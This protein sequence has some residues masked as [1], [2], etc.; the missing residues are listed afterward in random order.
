[1]SHSFEVMLRAQR[2]TDLFDHAVVGSEIVETKPRRTRRQ[3]HIDQ[4]VHYAEM[5][6]IK[7]VFLFPGQHA[8]RVVAF[9]GIEEQ[10]GTAG[11]CARAGQNLAEETGVPVCLVDAGLP[12]L[13]DYLGV[14]NALTMTADIPQPASIQ[15]LAQK[16]D[17]ENLFF[18]SLGQIFEG[19]G[20]AWKSDAWPSRLNELRRAF[21]YVLLAAPPVSSN[22][23]TVLLGKG[24]DGVIL[25]L[26]S[27]LTRRER[28]RA[29]KQSFEEA[30]VQLLGAVLNNHVHAIPDKLY[31]MF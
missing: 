8:P 1:V 23:N 11:I 31:K 19:V 6:L 28:A 15:E 20:P 18:V 22:P 3:I 16:L 24:T 2:E 9:C 21:T 4:S 12:S 27:E 25:V 13:Q 10:G 5:E 30:N 17:A 7:R 26:E 14:E 29:I